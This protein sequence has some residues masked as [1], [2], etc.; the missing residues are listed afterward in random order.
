MAE[1][2]DDR[3]LLLRAANG[4]ELFRFR[5]H[6]QNYILPVRW[7]NAYAPTH[8]SGSYTARRSRPWC[9]RR[10]PAALVPVVADERDVIAALGV[11]VETADRA[12]GDLDCDTLYSTYQRSGTVL[13]DR[14]VSGGSGLYTANEIE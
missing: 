7:S 13:S 8:E 6:R 11:A 14:S 4:D 5:P 2:P 1:I 9:I 3:A 12:F 10:T